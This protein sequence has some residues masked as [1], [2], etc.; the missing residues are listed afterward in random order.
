MNK[1]PHVQQRE[2]QRPPREIAVVEKAIGY[3][4]NDNAAYCFF[5]DAVEMIDLAG[6][7]CPQCGIFNSYEAQ[8]LG[9]GPTSR[10]TDGPLYEVRFCIDDK[11]KLIIAYRRDPTREEMEREDR[12]I[13]EHVAEL[14]TKAGINL[15]KN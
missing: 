7:T 8:G 5:F 3:G 12:G 4:P 1:L 2:F 11:C 15:D 6:W 10:A 13:I 14:Y 9:Q